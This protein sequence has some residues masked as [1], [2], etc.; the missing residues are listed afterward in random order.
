MVESSTV[1][2]VSNAMASSFVSTLLLLNVGA[3]CTIVDVVVVLRRN[4][5]GEAAVFVFIGTEAVAVLALAV[6]RTCVLM[7]VP[8]CFDQTVILCF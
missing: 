5:V 1:D 7:V 3:S 2:N 6:S 8:C 4:G